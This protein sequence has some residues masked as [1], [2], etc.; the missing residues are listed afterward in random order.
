[1]CFDVIYLGVLVS[2]FYVGVAILFLVRLALELRLTHAFCLLRSLD[3][4]IHLK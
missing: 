3:H 1:M 4:C 2:V